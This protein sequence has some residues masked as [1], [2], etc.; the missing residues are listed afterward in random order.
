MKLVNNT[1]T[2]AF[3]I[4]IGLMA[5]MSSVAPAFAARNVSLPTTESQAGLNTFVDSVVNGN[6]D[7]VVGIYVADKFAMP[8]VQQLEGDHAFISSMPNTLTQ[9]GLPSDYGV[10]GVLAHNT[11]A[12]A[13]FYDLETGDEVVAVYGDGQLVRYEID[14]SEVWEAFNPHDPYNGTFEN[15]ETSETLSL[16]DLFFDTYTTADTLVFQTCYAQGDNT[17]WGRLFITATLVD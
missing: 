5:L 16:R 3:A 10:L 13:S 2:K 17:E 7:Q 6:A 11:E 9:F 12:G 4:I 1:R 8:M 14:T 15:V